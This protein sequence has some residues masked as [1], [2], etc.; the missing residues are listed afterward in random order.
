MTHN[1]TF[2]FFSELFPA[3]VSQVPTTV[4]L[5]LF[6]VLSFQWGNGHFLSWTVL[7]P[8]SVE[9]F[10][11]DISPWSMTLTEFLFP[12]WYCAQLTLQQLTFL[13]LDLL[14]I[15]PSQFITLGYRFLVLLHCSFVFLLF[16]RW[17]SFNPVLSSADL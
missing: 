8:V 12:N 11:S 3:A 13:F 9:H 6:W 17:P 15:S 2:I 16:D 10:P 14:S 1:P 7:V 4:W 5:F